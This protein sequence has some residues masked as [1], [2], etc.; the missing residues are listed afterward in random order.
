MISLLSSINH[1]SCLDLYQKFTKEY[2][3]IACDY[4]ASRFK[5][6]LLNLRLLGV[7]VIVFVFDKLIMLWKYYAYIMIIIGRM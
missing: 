5:R 1:E 2:N 6:E 3:K 4:K 7:V